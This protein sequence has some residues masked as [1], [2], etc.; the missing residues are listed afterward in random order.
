MVLLG[1][2]S[3]DTKLRIPH[4]IIKEVMVN[5][6]KDVLVLRNRGI[7]NLRRILVPIVSG[8]NS[9]LALRVAMSLAYQPEIHV[10]VLHLTPEGLDDE[11]MEDTTLYIQ[12]VVENTLGEIPSWMD[13]DVHPSDSL[14]GGIIKKAEEG[15]YDLIIIGAGTETFSHRFL[16][17]A[18]N[19]RLIEDVN[20]SML[21]V[22]RYRPEAA[23]WLDNRLRRL[24]E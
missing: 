23:V 24:E 5:A 15:M 11:K 6:R 14:G 16:F 3:V 7:E 22:R 13:I 12:E 17:G 20:C 1:W 2:P 18:L 4:N 9:R 8:P 10:T 21:I 19:D